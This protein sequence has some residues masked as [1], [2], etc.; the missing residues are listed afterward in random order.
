M[1]DQPM[2]APLTW[3]VTQQ[4]EGVQRLANG[5]VVQGVT[6]SYQ[7]SNGDTGQVF[8]PMAD[9]I[10]PKVAQAI[11]AAAE[12]KAAVGKLSGKVGA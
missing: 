3:Q 6:I 10:T 2:T 1:A 4:V 7:L 12:M 11:Q 9:Y 8:V 5:Q